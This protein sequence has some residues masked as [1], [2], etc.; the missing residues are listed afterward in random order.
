MSGKQREDRSTVCTERISVW[1]TETEL[2][3]Y[4]ELARK[5]GLSVSRWIKSH[6]FAKREAT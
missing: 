1:C 5:A 3:A 6:L 4:R 2:E